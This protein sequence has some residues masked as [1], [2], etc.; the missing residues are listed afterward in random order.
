MICTL[1]PEGE[2]Q[3][4]S[5]KKEGHLSTRHSLIKAQGWENRTA[6][7]SAIPTL[8]T[9]ALGLQGILKDLAAAGA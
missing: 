8:L 6:G 3:V 4:S 9:L 5:V 7:F 1:R 2:V